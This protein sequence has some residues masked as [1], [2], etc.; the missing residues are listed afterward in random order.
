MWTW[1]VVSKS[2]RAVASRPRSGNLKSCHETAACPTQAVAAW[3]RE[4]AA[5]RKGEA[6]P[7]RSEC[8]SSTAG[9]HPRRN[10]GPLRC[11]YPV[12]A[13]MA[14]GW[15]AVRGVGEMV[16]MVT[17]TGAESG[18]CVWPHWGPVWRE[19]PGREKELG[20]SEQGSGS[21]TC[22]RHP[23]DCPVIGPAPSCQVLVAKGGDLL[24]F[25]ARQ[26]LV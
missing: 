1:K 26:P 12:Y 5:T 18:M 11:G 23:A 3:Q 4:R 25:L 15:E 14:D 10:R 16:G 20:R 24:T 19:N 17:Q 2:P 6:L 13:V 21:Q 9:S 22:D 8:V 7:C